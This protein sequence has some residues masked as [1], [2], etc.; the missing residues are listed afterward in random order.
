MDEHP[1]LG[2]GDQQV[3]TAQG[4]RNSKAF[5]AGICFRGRC[6]DRALAGLWGLSASVHSS[7]PTSPPRQNVF[8]S[9]FLTLML[10]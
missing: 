7:S 10:L 4:K 5:G 3:G 1:P 8:Y 6:T 2:K 9:L